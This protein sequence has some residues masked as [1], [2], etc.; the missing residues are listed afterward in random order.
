[1]SSLMAPLIFVCVTAG[2]YLLLASWSS[3]TVAIVHEQLITQ[4]RGA[5]TERAVEQRGRGEKNHSVQAKGSNHLAPSLPVVVTA[6]DPKLTVSPKVVVKSAWG[7]EQETYS[8]IFP[9]SGQTTTQKPRNGLSA[10]LGDLLRQYRFGKDRE[11]IVSKLA[12]TNWSTA[13]PVQTT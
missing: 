12:K 5:N 4:I 11:S 3:N 7:L 2:I 13:N 10:Q 1:G 6:R 9:W 8:Q